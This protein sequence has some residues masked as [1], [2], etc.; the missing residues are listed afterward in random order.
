MRTVHETDDAQEV[1][2]A[3]IKSLKSS[4]FKKVEIWWVGSEAMDMLRDG[5]RLCT[6][7]EQSSSEF[8]LKLPLNT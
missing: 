3:F 6:A 7:A 2:R 8:D 4:F 5:K 1:M